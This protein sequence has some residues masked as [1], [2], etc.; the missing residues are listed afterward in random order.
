M[1]HAIKSV[2]PQAVIRRYERELRKETHINRALRLFGAETCY[3]EI[4]VRDGACIRHIRATRKIA[5]DPAPIGPELIR[6]DGTQLIEL[7]SDDFFAGPANDLF[8]SHPIHVALVDGLH[9]FRQTLRDIMN[10]GRHLA[11]GGIVF[12]HDLNPPTRRHAEDMNGPW[13]GDVGKVGAYLTRFRPDLEFFTLDCDWGLGVVTGFTKTQTPVREQDVE[14]IAALDYADLE[15]D[16]KA[17]LRLRSPLSA[18]PYLL[19]RR[20]TRG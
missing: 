13:N 11:K 4:G 15:R 14:T 20:L 7:T 12:A 18:A 2:M 16:R 5:V 9:E 10:I 17:I 8:S 1:L 19:R 3:L 6:A